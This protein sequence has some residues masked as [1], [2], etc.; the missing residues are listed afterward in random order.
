MRIPSSLS[1][2]KIVIR[3]CAVALKTQLRCAMLRYT[4]QTRSDRPQTF[5]D[6]LKT[7]YL[8]NSAACQSASREGHGIRSKLRSAHDTDFA[9]FYIWVAMISPQLHT[10]QRSSICFRPT[11]PFDAPCL[12]IRASVSR[13]SAS[14]PPN[15][16]Q[17]SRSARKPT[18]SL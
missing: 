14:L 2:L 17:C 10:S 5:H 18:P 7:R 11:Q 15:G 9:T 16:T 6:S 1:N 8:I 13:S 12:S 4:S 3:E